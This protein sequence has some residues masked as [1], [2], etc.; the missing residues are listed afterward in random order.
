MHGSANA[1]NVLVVVPPILH[2][3]LKGH[4]LAML[5]THLHDPGIHHAIPNM[6]IRAGAML[7]WH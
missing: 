4:K 6:Q 1:F 3:A 7:K 5:A 2:I